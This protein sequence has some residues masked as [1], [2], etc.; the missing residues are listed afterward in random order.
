MERLWKTTKASVGIAD[1][2][3]K[4]MPPSPEH[5]LQA[6]LLHVMSGRETDLTESAPSS[7]S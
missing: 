1:W 5:Y 4:P 3:S 2:D 6:N 7:I